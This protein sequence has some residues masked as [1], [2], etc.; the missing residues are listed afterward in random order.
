MCIRD[1]FFDSIELES[2]DIEVG[3]WVVAMHDNI[4]IGSREWTGDMIDVPAMG[5]DGTDH[6]LGYISDGQ[7]PRFMVY[8][9]RSDSF[10]EIEA[11]TVPLWEN[12]L[13]TTLSDVTEKV[14]IPSQFMMH[15]PYPNPFNPVT[16]ISFDI[17]I[18]S[19]V[20][21]Q[22]Y[23]IN[24]RHVTEIVNSILSAG[25]YQ[26]RWDARMI[27][28]GLYFI[29]ISAGDFVQTSKVVLIK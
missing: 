1:S 13:I 26:Y 7:V 24:G 15:N 19:D 20:V 27:A 10:I 2:D 17:P 5:Y 28:S 3:D 18:D 12:N 29:N 14:A 23:D 11:R 21:I 22:V 8:K 16:N 9:T 25:S 4:I 6:T